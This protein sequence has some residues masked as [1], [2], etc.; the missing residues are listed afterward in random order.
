MPEIRP[1]RGPSGPQ[2]EFLQKALA[3]LGVHPGPSDGLFGRKTEAVVK[4]FQRKAGL[5][6]DGLVGPQTFGAIEAMQKAAPA[7]PKRVAAPKP[8]VKPVVKPAFKPAAKPAP[9]KPQAQRAI[10]S[11]AGPPRRGG[12]AA[13]EGVAS[14]SA[15]VMAAAR[16][17]GVF[18][19]GLAAAPGAGQIGPA[20]LPQHAR[21]WDEG[22]THRSPPGAGSVGDTLPLLDSVRRAQARGW[23]LPERGFPLAGPCRAAIR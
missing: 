19:A 14:G 9:K 2:V 17:G 21:Q 6:E 7:A 5:Q 18:L 8:V 11:R 23:R 13:C 20:R 4:R 10:G 16:A 3:A 1:A 12:P 15:E 22:R